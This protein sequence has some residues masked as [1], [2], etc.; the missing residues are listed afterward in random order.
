VLEFSK[1]AGTY[2]N[3][4][5]NSSLPDV[6]MTPFHWILGKIKALTGMEVLRVMLVAGI[7]NILFLYFSVRWFCSVVLKERSFLFHSFLIFTILFFWGYNPWDY[8]GF[9]HFRFINFVLPYP[10]TFGFCLL[11]SGLTLYDYVLNQQTRLNGLVV[12]FIYNVFTFSFLFLTHPLTFIFYN[13][14]IAAFF[15]SQL[16][17][18]Q[19]RDKAFLATT[20]VPIIVS[21]GIV[22]LYPHYPVADFFKSGGSNFHLANFNMYDDRPLLRLLP[23]LCCIPLLYSLPHRKYS[24]LKIF[25]T[26]LSALYVYGYISGKYSYG[27]SIS[28][29]YFCVQVG[30]V[31]YLKQCFYDHFTCG[32]PFKTGRAVYFAVICGLFLIN[33]SQLPMTA[34]NLLT[35]P[36]LDVTAIRDVQK[37]VKDPAAIVVASDKALLQKL[38]TFMGKGIVPLQP[39]IWIRDERERQRALDSFFLSKNVDSS[40]QHLVRTYGVTHVLL[41]NSDTASLSRLA[42]PVQYRNE[43]YTLLGIAGEEDLSSH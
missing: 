39:T 6:Y 40:R 38:P 3:P 16:Y 28:L 31:L 26:L 2:L 10:S 8:S 21:A 22:F 34:Y 30:V 42:Y 9:F 27:R 37:E 4:W 23:V 5:I 36:A 32:K 15:L 20:V 29:V 33:L 1:K 19:F 11:L 41:F 24:F 12:L 13:V 17:L 25:F 35:A 7:V 14:G 43:K 18:K